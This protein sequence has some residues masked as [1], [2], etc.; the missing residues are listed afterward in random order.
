MPTNRDRSDRAGPIED[1][2]ANKASK[3]LS[4]AEAENALYIDFE[5]RKDKPPVLLGATHRKHAMAVYQYLTDPRYAALGEPNGLQVLTLSEAVLRII[6]RAEAN[7]RLIV[8][9]TNHELNVVEH[10]APEPLV[11]FRSRYR[12]ALAIAKYWRNRSHD[13]DRPATGTLANYLDLVCYDVP[14]GAGSGR[15]GATIDILDKALARDPS[16]KR[17]TA[18]QRQRW[19]DLRAHDAHDCVGMRRVC[20]LAAA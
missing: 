14:E 16:A 15:A 19:V 1:T 13:G 18:K 9:W 4:P 5:G 3:R 17:L 12:N 20:E 10:Y 6:Q 2:V 11:R 8:A 7:D